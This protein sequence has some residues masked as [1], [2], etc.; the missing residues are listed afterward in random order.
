MTILLSSKAIV[1]RLRGK[2]SVVLCCATCLFEVLYLFLVALSSLPE[3]HLSDT[4][5][6]TV[7]SWTLL[8]ARAFASLHAAWLPPVLLALT[9]ILLMGTYASAILG[10]LH[11]E[12]SSTTRYGLLLL[13]GS[14]FLFG[15][16]LLL[17]PRLFSDDVFTHIFSGRILAV[18]HADPL[19][20]APVQFATDPYL[21]WVISGRDTPNIYGPLWLRI[22]SL[23][24]GIS[25][26]PIVTLLLFKG[27]ELLA[28]L[29]TCV[30]TWAIL[31]KIA[32]SRRL[33]GTLLYAWNPLALLELAGSGHSEGVLLCLLLLATWLYVQGQA[34][35]Y[36]VSS[37]LVFGLA[38][39][40]NL[41]TL[42][43]VSLSTWF[44]VRAERRIFT[45]VQ[46]FCWR[47]LILLVPALII[48]LPFWHGATTFLALTS[49]I[50]MEH[51]VHSPVG[52]LAG[53]TRALFQFVADQLHFPPFLHPLIAADVTLRASAAFI[54]ALIYVDL[55]SRVRH[56]P[57]TLAGMHYSSDADPAMTLPGF[58]VLLTSWGV[59]IFWYIVLVSG[60]FWPWYMLWMLWIV[61]LRR[62]DVFTTTVLLL[63][64]TALLLYP[65]LGLVRASIMMYQSALI[66]GIPLV[67]LLLA[68]GRERKAERITTNYDR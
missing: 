21:P 35:G 2:L 10:V 1:E 12:E 8:F 68:R 27:V 67:Y 30:L 23:L 20:T 60:W 4:P 46:G 41:I 47:M 14:A 45:R 33:L 24:A 34:A 58:D 55:F 43:L 51:F 19:N 6:T 40:A 52:A 48:S 61:T 11:L 31:A 9:L 63:S 15:L 50:D 39:S 13:L 7:W 49:T 57:G 36:R 44:D 28:H 26:N 56:A 38:L 17:Q 16:T 5:L 22:A 54:F 29:L 42:L 65:L 18:Y 3:L 66:F 32:P 59:A 25:R 37:L 53:P 62:L 64:G